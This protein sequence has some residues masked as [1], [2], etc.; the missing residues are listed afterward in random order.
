MRFLSKPPNRFEMARPAKPPHADKI[1]PPHHRL[2]AFMA[3]HE[4]LR[5][6]ADALP[7]GWRYGVEISAMAAALFDLDKHQHAAL[8]GD[9]VNLASPV[10]EVAG[11]DAI[12]LQA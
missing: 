2:R 12:A 8:T 4:S 1:E 11:Q 5:R 9:N 10:A 3:S 7:L 6:R